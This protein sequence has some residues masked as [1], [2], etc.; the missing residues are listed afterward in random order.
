MAG[1]IRIIRYTA[2][3]LLGFTGQLAPLLGRCSVSVIG[4]TGYVS[5]LDKALA[6]AEKLKPLNRFEL[7][8]LKPFIETARLERRQAFQQSCIEVSGE[9]PETD[10]VS[11]L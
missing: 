3:R 2:L 1:I 9:D 6:K 11:G 4:F 8:L 7:W 5:A 10:W